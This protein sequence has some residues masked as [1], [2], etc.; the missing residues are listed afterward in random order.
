MPADLDIILAYKHPA[1]VRRFQKDFPEKANMAEEL[2]SDLLR[3]FFAS[4]KHSIERERLPCKDS[5]DFI[6]IMDE[7]MREID[8]IWHIFLLYTQD[9]MDFCDK[10]FGEYLHHQPD[11]VP[12]FRKGSFNFE[13]N[14]KKFLNYVYD[15][16]GEEVVQRWFTKSCAS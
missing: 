15:E 13:K 10:Y 16:L 4:K 9:Y 7:E 2:F 3:F 11:I 12:T 5:L 14:L 1:V 6:F 8:Q